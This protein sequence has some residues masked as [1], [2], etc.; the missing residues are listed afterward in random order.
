MLASALGAGRSQLAR[1][2]PVGSPEVNQVGVQ[3]EHHRRDPF[4]RM[5]SRICPHVAFRRADNRALRELAGELLDS[6]PQRWEV[7]AVRGQQDDEP[8]PLPRQAAS[9]RHRDGGQRAGAKRERS[10]LVQVPIRVADTL[11]SADA[12]ISSRHVFGS[13]AVSH[14]G[15]FSSRSA[16]TGFGPRAAM[17]ERVAAILGVAAD[18]VS[19]K[20][21]TTE[22]LG[23]TGRGEG[24]AAQA[25]ATVR[26]PL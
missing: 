2:P 19:V 22:K 14:T 6:G 13:G 23:F 9:D 20:A 3:R 4:A 25:V 16:A 7:A 1:Q 17:V 8:E 24:I 21:T 15:T 18:R 5:R 26:L 11:R 12:A 10:V